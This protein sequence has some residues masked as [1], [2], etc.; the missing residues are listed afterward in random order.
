MRRELRRACSV[1]AMMSTEVGIPARAVE[2]A[3]QRRDNCKG[4]RQDEVAG[5]LR[6]PT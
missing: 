5:A 1:Y 4:I 6:S 2:Y 3:L